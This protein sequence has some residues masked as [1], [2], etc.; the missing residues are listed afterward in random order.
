MSV[1]RHVARP[2]TH[3]SGD[4]ALATLS[5]RA[6]RT[7]RSQHAPFGE[8]GQAMIH[9]IAPLVRLVIFGAGNDARPLC[10]LA[11]SLGWH[12]A[13][14]DRRKRLAT[15]ARFPEADQVVAGDWWA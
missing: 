6:L 12:V 11:R 7:G 9:Y 1:R 10:S 5:R 8:R 4:P 14:A 2:G 13:I 3:H 15:A